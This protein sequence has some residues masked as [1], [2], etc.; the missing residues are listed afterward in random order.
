MKLTDFAEGVQTGIGGNVEMHKILECWPIKTLNMAHKN[1]ICGF[2]GLGS[3]NCLSFL[4]I[5]ENLHAHKEIDPES[6]KFKQNLDC[7]YPFSI[8]LASN[9]RIPFGAKSI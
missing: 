4:F 6:G 3:S 1:L 9:R 7:N 8:N 5:L 2:Q